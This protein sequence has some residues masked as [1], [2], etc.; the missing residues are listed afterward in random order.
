MDLSGFI[1]FI[2]ASDVLVAASTGPLHIAAALGKAAIG[3]YPPIRP[4]DF[5]RW[6]PLGPEASSFSLVKSCTDCRD[7]P[8]QCIC[9]QGI[10]AEDIAEE[11]VSPAGR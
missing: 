3:I 2:A 4:M 8:Q 10:E 11:I 5:G 1:A 7:E 6:G 9:M